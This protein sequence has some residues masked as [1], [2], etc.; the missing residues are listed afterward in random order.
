MQKLSVLCW[1]PRYFIR[2]KN[3]DWRHC[4]FLHKAFSAGEDQFGIDIRMRISCAGMISVNWKYLKP[5]FAK[6]LLRSKHWK[7]SSLVDP[8]F[9]SDHLNSYD[10]IYAY[11]AFPEHS[12]TPVIW[13]SGPTDVEL[14]KKRGIPNAVIEDG[15]Q[16]KRRGI[17]Q[18]RL[19]AVSSET[20]RMQFKRQF[21]E[22]R[23][24][25]EVL[26]FVLPNVKAIAESELLK[27][28]SHGPVRIVFVGRQA[29]LKGLD[30]LV[31][32]YNSIRAQVTDLEFFVVSNM[33]GGKVDLPLGIRHIYEMPHG[34][35]QKLLR[36]AHILAMPSRE[37]SFG[38]VYLEAFAA[39]AVV[40]APDREP[41]RSLLC[42]GVAGCL[43]DLEV[44]SIARCLLDL[45]KS[46]ERRIQ[47][48]QEALSQFSN[49]YSEDVVLRQYADVF[50]KAHSAA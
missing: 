31:Q 44:G 2:P 3:T 38:L 13:H 19:I 15:L 7:Y 48:A 39:G 21:P 1:T 41:Q 50:R 18:A 33:S 9:K 12:S 17:R 14:L 46:S 27:K 4:H 30:L 22:S 25:I 26:P 29:K 16:Q 40:I 36:T 43:V 35:V 11:G 49:N 23:G 28:H 42:N 37:E 20:A 10:L 34:D 5:V 24:R 47:L 6:R 32:A 45:V 8:V